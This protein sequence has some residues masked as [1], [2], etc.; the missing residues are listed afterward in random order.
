MEII[1]LEDWICVPMKSVQ[2]LDIDKD[3][4]RREF[5]SISLTLRLIHA[6]FTRNILAIRNFSLITSQAPKL[7]SH[8]YR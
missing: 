7:I 5:V 8:C 2:V 3:V 6:F 4:A 1:L